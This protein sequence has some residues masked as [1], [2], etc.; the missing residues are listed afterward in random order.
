MSGLKTYL[1]GDV[2]VI[3]SSDIMTMSVIVVLTFVLFYFLYRPL[4]IVSFDRQFAYSLGIP[5]RLL[6]AVF[7][8]FLAIA[9]VISLQAVGVVLVSAMLIIPAATAYLLADRMN[10]MIFSA[11]VIG[12]ISAILGVFFFLSLD[13]IC[14]QVHSWSY[15]Q[16]CYLPWLIYFPLKWQDH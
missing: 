9:I 4:L 3:D 16:V 2:A 8:M 7:Q 13:L 15:L 1:F 14:Q 11:I 10:K 12:V 6:D 5:V